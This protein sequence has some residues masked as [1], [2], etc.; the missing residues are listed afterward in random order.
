MVLNLRQLISDVNVRWGIE[1]LGAD[2]YKI[3]AIP[4]YATGTGASADLM[5]ALN[6]G[7]NLISIRVQHLDGADARNNTAFD[8]SFVK[9]I[10]GVPFVYVI[11]DDSTVIDFYEAF[12][13]GVVLDPTIYAFRQNSTAGH[14]IKFEIVVECEEP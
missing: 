2:Q 6:R 1:Y 7:C 11:Y 9:L 4:P 12:G 8:W 14:H 10:T 5:F 13:G 3:T